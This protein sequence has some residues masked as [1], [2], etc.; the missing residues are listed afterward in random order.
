[1]KTVQNENDAQAR[2]EALLIEGVESG[3]STEFDADDWA[4]IRAEARALLEQRKKE[5]AR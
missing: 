1:M 2:L 5:K 4:E 3:E